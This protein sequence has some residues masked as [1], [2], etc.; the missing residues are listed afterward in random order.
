MAKCNITCI[1]L[2][3]KKLD[4]MAMFYKNLFGVKV[5]RYGRGSDKFY[6]G[7]FSGID[8]VLVPTG[9]RNPSS[10]EN[11]VHFDIFVPDLD[12]VI[13]LVK[14]NAGKTNN[15]LAEFGSIKCIGVFDP[16]GNF[17]AVKQKLTV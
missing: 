5:K 3:S 7:K 15:R 9:K 2:I 11:K 4:K 1:T 13:K 6:A 8:F 10:F 16:D 17:I 12:K 14:K